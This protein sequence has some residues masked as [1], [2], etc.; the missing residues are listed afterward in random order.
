MLE[1]VNWDLQA[2]VEQLFGGPATPGQSR[3]G[4]AL[5]GGPTDVPMDHH[6]HPHEMDFEEEAALINEEMGV[7]MPQPP[8]PDT[9]DQD[10]SDAQLAAA[11]EAS[12]L[13]QTNAGRE[14]SEEELIAQAMRMSQQEEDKRQRQEL[15]DQQ[16]AELQESMLMDQMRE[17]QAREEREAAAAMAKAEEQS[18]QEAA[19]RAAQE[20]QQAR[21]ESEAK[22][23][24]LPEEPPAGDPLRVALMLRLP[25][26]TRL[27]RSFRSSEA[28]GCLY[29]FVDLQCEELA[30]QPYRLVSTMP[31]KA[32]EDREPTLQDAGIKNQ[33]VLMVELQSG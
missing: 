9:A 28:V 2:A 10:G 19:N 30:G 1:V 31:R 27:Q 11:I 4:T 3:P 16:E 21:A 8:R 18:R 17:H 12:F 13:A 5:M 23:A 22:R 33:F 15:R 32:Y 29:D 24:R 25:N 20:A 26:G 6:P 7:P 14:A